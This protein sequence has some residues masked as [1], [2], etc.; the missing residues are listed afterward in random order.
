MIR[1]DKIIGTFDLDTSTVK[2]I[3]MKYLSK[4]ESQNRLINISNE[5]PKTFI[6]CSTDDGEKVYLSN[7]RSSTL[8]KRQN[9]LD[10]V[11]K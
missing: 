4:M 6:V 3:T 5:L 7:L 11:K 10:G 2:K 1:E 9:L 8:V